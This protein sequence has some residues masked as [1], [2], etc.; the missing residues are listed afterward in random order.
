MRDAQCHYVKQRAFLSQDETERDLNALL[1][2]PIA[3]FAA[4][5]SNHAHDQ[6][7]LDER[8]RGQA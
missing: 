1:R 5:T 3:V 2:L 7:P 8:D 6:T 4:L